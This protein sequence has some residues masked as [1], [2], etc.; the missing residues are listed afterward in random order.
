MQLSRGQRTKL[1]DIGLSDNL[2]KVKVDLDTHGL[3]VDAACFGLD[4]AKKLSDERYMTFFNQPTSP[5]GGVKLNGTGVFEFNLT[6]LPGAIDS[7]CITLA[8]DGAGQMNQLGKCTVSFLRGD[9]LVG[10]Y[11]FDGSHF[12]AERAIMLLEIYRKDGNWR[13]CPVGQGFNGGL[14]ALVTH[15]GGA[16]AEKPTEQAAPSPV[17][18]LPTPKVSLSKVVLEKRGEKISL[19]KRGS[20]AGHGKI[21]CNLNW[22][23]PPKTEQKKGFFG[24][25]VGGKPKGIDLD[26]GCLFEMADGSKSVVQA[27]GNQYGAF[28]SSPYIHM[29][30]D[31]RTGANVTGEFLYI[32]GDHLRDLKRVCIFAFIYEGVASWGQADGIVTLTVPEHPPIEVRLD[33]HDNSKNM[34][35]IAMLENDAGSLKITKLGEYF[36]GHAELDKRYGWGMRW[37][38]GS[39]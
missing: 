32:N 38:A 10:G 15:F 5:C 14:D 31:D 12:A 17:P 21:V 29:A 9:D 4:G 19:E 6:R 22:S 24:N 8:I 7:L 25:L 2:F 37:V 35:A 18:P 13:L 1:S 11:A 39:K 36:S 23:Q 3:S 34:C 27:L 30:G 33:N 20:G 26:L 16:V 28:N